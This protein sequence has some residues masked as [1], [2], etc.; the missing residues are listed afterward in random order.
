M[1][2]P[3]KNYTFGRYRVYFDQF[4]PGTKTP[5]GQRYLGNTPELNMTSESENLDHFDA[6]NG[7]RIKDDSMLLELNRAGS[8]VTDH[9]SPENLA[10][11][12]LGDA[13]LVTQASAAAQSEAQAAQAALQHAQYRHHR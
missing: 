7:I 5:T 11:F 6:D 3:Q 13:S 4:L 9:I 2:F 1:P 12:F 8:F 10:L